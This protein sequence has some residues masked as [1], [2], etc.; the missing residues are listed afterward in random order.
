M[1]EAKV[2]I[3]SWPDIVSIIL[4]LCKAAVQMS[5]EMMM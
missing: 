1:S 5:P 4:A 2:K 3:I